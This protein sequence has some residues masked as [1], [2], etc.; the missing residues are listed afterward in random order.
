ML[1]APEKL[2]ITFPIIGFVARGKDA[3]QK[4]YQPRRA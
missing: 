4:K 1:P 2:R 3:R